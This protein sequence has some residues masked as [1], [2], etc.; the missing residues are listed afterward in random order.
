MQRVLV[1]TA[2]GAFRHAHL[3][4]LLQPGKNPSLTEAHVAQNA[5]IRW[6]QEAGFQV[7]WTEDVTQ[8]AAPAK[9]APYEAVVFLSNSR[10]VLDDASQ[11]ALL[12][13]VRA[14][15]GFV[16][17]HNALG[18]MNQWLWFR[19]LL[20]GANFYDHGPHRGGQV[21]TV[22][23]KDASTQNLPQRWD[24]RDEWYNLVPFPT[25][26]RVLAR[27]D[28]STFEN[29][30]AQGFNGHHGHSG[31]HPVSWR[32]DYDGGRAWITSLGHDPAAWE[33]KSGLVGQESFK[34]HV[35]GGVLS[36]MRAR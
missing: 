31:N 28:T 3:G 24:F 30:I 13:Y 21:V 17:I 15:G 29:G 1:F 16:A 9:L 4:P 22:D 25:D 12:H 19:G 7:D 5:M 14:G 26:V 35:I 18:A 20:G 10:S 11:T 23:R 6:G 2:T 27:V 33:D 36:A 32:H 34:E 8:M